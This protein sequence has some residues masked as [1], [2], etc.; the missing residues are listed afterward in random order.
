MINS[1]II[2]IFKNKFEHK[3][4]IYTIKSLVFLSIIDDINDEN[5][6]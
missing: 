4:L 1:I 2:L 3:G 6:Y 5:E